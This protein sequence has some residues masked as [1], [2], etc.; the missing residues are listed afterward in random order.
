[1]SEKSIGRRLMEAVDKE[2][3]AEENLKQLQ[4]ATEKV[5]AGKGES[6]IASA[7]RALFEAVGNLAK[8]G[9]WE[10]DC[11][12]VA[13]KLAVCRAA[14]AYHDAHRD[15]KMLDALGESL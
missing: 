8:C 6:K 9:N 14:V 13:L 10:I 12:G 2:I 15:D 1:M 3:M 4:L 11:F 7:E 5:L